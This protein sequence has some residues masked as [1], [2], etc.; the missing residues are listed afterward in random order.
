MSNSSGRKAAQAIINMVK[1]YEK[2]APTKTEVFAK[3]NRNLSASTRY[4][5]KGFTD[6]WDRWL[7]H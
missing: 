7:K 6:L 3:L 2:R 1:Q 4:T 5:G